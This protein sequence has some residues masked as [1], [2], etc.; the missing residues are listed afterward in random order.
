[1]KIF[2]TDFEVELVMTANR[3]QPTMNAAAGNDNDSVYIYDPKYWRHGYLHGYRT[4]PLA[5][6]GTADKAQ[7]S[8]DWTLKCLAEESA[9]VV[10]DVDAS[11]AM[12]G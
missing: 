5:K 4:E 3:L 6:T 7:I 9:G 12:V 11:T 10:A 8:V 2:I 1:M